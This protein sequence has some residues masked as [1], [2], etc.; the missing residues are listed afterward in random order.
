MADGIDLREFRKLT[1]DLKGFKPDKQVKKALKMAGQLIADDA[2]II[3]SPHSKTVPGTI[4]VRQRK[5]SISV[6]AGGTNVPIAGLLEMG[7]KGRKHHGKFRHPVFGDKSVWVE[8]D[9]H[10]FLLRAS[11]KNERVIERFEGRI[12]A[13]A[14][15]EVGWHGA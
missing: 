6:I 7:N 3:V 15:R 12:I 10:P 1:R 8:Q 13:E 4:K 9:M 2:R 11:R 5:T 14:F